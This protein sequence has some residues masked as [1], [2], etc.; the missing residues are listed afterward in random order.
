MVD[1]NYHTESYLLAAVWTKSAKYTKIFEGI[2]MIQEAENNLPHLLSKY[3]NKV[4]DEFENF[5]LQNNFEMLSKS[6]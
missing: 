1:N 4:L 5:L 6:F 2:R 3:R